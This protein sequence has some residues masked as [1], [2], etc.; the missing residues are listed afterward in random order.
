MPPTFDISPYIRPVADFPKPGILFRDITPLLG[1]PP[2]F[3]AVT[4]W[5]CQQI[6][7]MGAEAVVAMESRG[8]IF[9]APVAVSL[10]LPF[11]LVR[12]P[13]KLP[14]ATVSEK[15]DLE[16]GSNELH[17][18]RDSLHS[19]QKVAVID[20]LLATGGTAA[21]SCNLV[22]KLGANVVGV[23][24]VI[25]LKELEGRKKLEYERISSMVAY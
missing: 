10:N 18:H 7:E 3:R 9:A 15:Y 16:Y 8:F 1:H 6:R 2:A 24:F 20:D 12:K 13:G 5:L 21:A 17:M 14:T 22:R 23:C 4:E 25:E 19:G 11:I